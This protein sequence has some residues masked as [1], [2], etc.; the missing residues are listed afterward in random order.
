MKKLTT[1]LLVLLLVLGCAATSYATSDEPIKLAIVAPLTGDYTEYGLQ[2]LNAA[3]LAAEQVNAEG[4]VLGGR[5]I[6]IVEYDDRGLVDDGAAMAELIAAD[7]SILGVPCMDFQSTVA[8]VVGPIY[9]EAGIP[10]IS[11]TSSHPDLSLIGEYVLRNNTTDY[12]EALNTIEA[13]YL[14]GA[15]KIAYIGEETDFCVSAGENMKAAV[16]QIAEKDPSVE[17]VGQTSY[18]TGTVDFS[19]QIS[20]LV[21][22]EPDII[23]NSGTYEGFA[24]FCQQL[25]RSGSDIRVAGVGNIYDQNLITIG[26]EA[27]EGVIF[28]SL[29]NADSEN[30]VVQKFVAEFEE[31]TGGTMPNHMGALAYDATMMLINAVEVT[32]SDDRETVMKS[33]YTTP[34]EG[35][36]GTCIFEEDTHECI[37]PQVVFEV[38]D[39]AFVEIPNLLYPSWDEF[40]ASDAFGA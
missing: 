28:P 16:E 22:L 38:K 25:R 9:Q 3:Q 5:Q 39:G 34:Y 30:P 11:N 40:M 8:L 27:V 13:C 15:R 18:L 19:A 35:V 10:A 1:I 2:A 23:V 29:F 24:P 6:E 14:T 26:G 33:L 12:F 37:K 4:G 31:K 32:G 36:T 21:A 17:W 20:E 7:D